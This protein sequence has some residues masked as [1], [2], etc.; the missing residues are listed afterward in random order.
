MPAQS[1]RVFQRDVPAP[2]FWLSVALAAAV[3]A[4]VIVAIA[5]LGRDPVVGAP[6]QR[7]AESTS[8][9]W[10]E[11]VCQRGT[12]QNGRGDN[13]LT[14]STGSAMCRGH[15]GPVVIF[16]GTYE[17]QFRFENAAANFIKRGV[18]ATLNDDSGQLWVFYSTSN[19]ADLSP[20]TPF[21]FTMHGG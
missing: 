16:I 17:S 14:G 15:G 11:A 13:I 20:L 21:G 9:D 12:Y 4:L 8:Q 3:L 1:V 18:Y 6:T 19:R 5:L 10:I 2:V 7:H